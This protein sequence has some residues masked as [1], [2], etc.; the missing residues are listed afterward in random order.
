MSTEYYFVDKN[1]AEKVIGRRSCGWKPTMVIQDVFNDLRSLYDFYMENRD[2]L[3]IKDEYG[4]TLKW[5]D[6]EINL[7]SWGNNPK[8]SKLSL[9]GKYWEDDVVWV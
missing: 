4:R 6:L 5:R 8:N 1:G 2:N 9:S 3:T 7:I